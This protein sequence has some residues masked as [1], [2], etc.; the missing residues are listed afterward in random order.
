MLPVAAYEVSM[1][2]FWSTLFYRNSH[3]LLSFFAAVKQPETSTSPT[4]FLL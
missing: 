4:D 3:D 2:G 1:G